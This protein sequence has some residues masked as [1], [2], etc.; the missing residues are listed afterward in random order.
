MNY[1]RFLGA[2]SAAVLIIVVI[3]ILAPGVWAQAKFK[4]L[5]KFK[6]DKDGGVP[7]RH[8][9]FD[10]A[11]N[12]Y[13]TTKSGGNVEAPYCSSGCGVVFKLTPKADESWYETV[14]HRFTTSEGTLPSSGMIFDQAGNLYGT[15]AGGPTGGSVFKLMPNQDGSWTESNLYYF[16]GPFGCSDGARP[17]ASLIFDTVGNL[18][19]TTFYGGDHDMGVVFQL[20]PSSD[21]T[22][23]ENVLTSFKSNGDAAWPLSDLI[24]DADGDLFGTTASGGLGGD[25]GCWY[26]Q[27]CGTVFE[28]APN[29]GGGWTNKILHRFKPDNDKKGANP[30]AGLILDQKGNLYGTASLGGGVCSGDGGCGVVFK[31]TEDSD[32]RWTEQVLHRFTGGNDGAE[33]NADL[34]FDASANLYGVACGGGAHGYGVVFKLTLSPNGKWREKVLHAFRDN[35]GACPAG[36][37]IDGYGRLYGVTNGDGGGTFGS[38]FEITP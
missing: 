15:T 28:L 9:V 24:W 20:K 23:T 35:P 12:I 5:H 14:L 18:Y 27:G 11:G 6:N 1:K 32:G 10:A 21:G 25:S 3:F 22:W 31:L 8:L 29:P 26:T 13:G 17:M 33:P 7:N 16:C 30:V 38:V 37:T 34:I 36:L 2:A 4:T 19:G